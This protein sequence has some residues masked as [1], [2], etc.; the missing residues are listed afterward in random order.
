MLI[1]RQMGL[2]NL[3][4]TVDTYL[5]E[6]AEM[7]ILIGF[8]KTL[9][10]GSMCHYP[11]RQSMLTIL[12]RPITK[13]AKKPITIH[14]LLTHTSGLAYLFLTKD[15]RKWATY[16]NRRSDELSSSLVRTPGYP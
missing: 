3:Q 15:L 1:A 5:P 9:T 8:E 13:M 4:D 11:L 12:G 6:L 14:Q 7:E 16:N 2:L 10:G